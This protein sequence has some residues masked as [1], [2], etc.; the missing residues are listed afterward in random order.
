MKLQILG[1]LVLI[2]PSLFAQG[3]THQLTLKPENVHWGYYDAAVKPALRISSG[4]VVQVETM[5]ARGPERLRDA[6]IPAGEIP[7]SFW[8]IDAA[9]KD[10]LGAHPLTGPVFVESAEPG[11]TIA[12]RMI[13]FSISTRTESPGSF[14]ETVPCPMSFH[15]RA[16][17][18]FALIPEAKVSSSVLVS[19]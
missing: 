11:D 6:G 12:V 14:R 5:I 3:R 13:S 16:T 1:L 10:R 2:A 9:V 8:Q 17:R 7:E 19:G 4:D 15:I 18:S